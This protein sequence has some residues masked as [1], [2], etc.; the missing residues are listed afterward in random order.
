MWPSGI[1][2]FPTLVLQVSRQRRLQG[3]VT[4]VVALGAEFLGV[5]EQTPPTLLQG[6]A[7]VCVCQIMTS[8]RGP[9]KCERQR[10]TTVPG[11]GHT[12][13]HFTRFSVMNQFEQFGYKFQNMCE[14]E[15]SRSE[16]FAMKIYLWFKQKQP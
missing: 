8:H 7:V 5:P 13:S 16:H 3:S 1:K 11:L 4:G 2:R 12:G 9:L 15:I 6:K 14:I 10:F